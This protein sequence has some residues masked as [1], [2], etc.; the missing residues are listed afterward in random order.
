MVGT[1]NTMLCAKDPVTR[2][3]TLG[4]ILVDYVHEL[5]LLAGFFGDVKRLECFS[6]TL[7]DKELK[8]NPSLAAILIE[9]EKGEIVTVHMD[10]V[11]HPQRRVFEVYGDKRSYVYDFQ[12]DQLQIYDCEKEGF[13]VQMFYNVRDDQF[14]EE[15]QDMLDAMREGGRPRVT[16]EEALQSLKV[17]ELAIERIR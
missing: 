7:A 14:K 15:H 16:G 1:Y 4:S 11:Q 5:D 2:G 12:T 9:Y 10:Y 17:A 6:N 13:Q 8:A 3:E